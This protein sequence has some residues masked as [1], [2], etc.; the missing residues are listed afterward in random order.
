MV[1]LSQQDTDIPHV[2]CL[3]HSHHLGAAIYVVH[4]EHHLKGEGGGGKG[5]E[6]GKGGERRE[7]EK[8]LFNISESS[9]RVLQK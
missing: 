2:H 7:V 3:V 9:Q 5:E 4:L 1:P 8:Q 6:R